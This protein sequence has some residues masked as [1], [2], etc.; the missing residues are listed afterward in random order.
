MTTTPRRSTGGRATLEMVAERAGVSRGTASRV[1][2]GA[3]NVS[4]RAVK[5]VTRA[6]AEL[7]YRPNLSARSLVTGR[8][9]HLAQ[10]L[11]TTPAHAE[12]DED[13]CQAQTDL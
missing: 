4:E 1:L 6:A 9:G 3:P 5:A 10:C 11:G 12:Q 7:A 8:H 13:A 2:S